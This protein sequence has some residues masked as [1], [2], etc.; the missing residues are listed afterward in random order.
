MFGCHAQDECSKGDSCTK[1]RAGP[2]PLNKLLEAEVAPSMHDHP[3]KAGSFR[4]RC[5][6]FM[7]S[8]IHFVANGFIIK[9]TVVTSQRGKFLV[10]GQPK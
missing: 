7:G 1:P 4:G 6:V 8:G 3:L 10:L 5:L 9:V 2:W